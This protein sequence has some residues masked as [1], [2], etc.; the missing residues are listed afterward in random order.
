MQRSGRAATPIRP[1]LARAPLTVAPGHTAAIATRFFAGAKEIDVLDAY[2]AKL[3]IPLFGKAIDWGWFEI[4][5]KP[6]I[7]YLSFLYHLIG[8]FG[9]AVMAL[10][11]TVRGLM[12]PVAQ[13]GFKSMAAMRI[14][15]PKLKDIQERWKDDKVRQQQETM[16]LY[17]TEKVNPVAGCLPVL[18]Q[19][20]IFFALYKVLML[21]IEMRHQAFIVPWIS[22]LSA[23]DPWSPV[24]LFGV[25]PF[26]PHIIA[27]GV[28][29]MILGVTMYMQFKLNPAPADPVQAQMMSIM[30][31]VMMFVMAPFAAGL[32]L[33]WSTSNILTILQQKWLYSQYPEMKTAAVKP[34][35]A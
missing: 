22:D 34:T 25:L 7:K 1:D 27:I 29:P 30:P 23:P 31:W 35:V 2:Q 24:N 32:Q 5:E 18:I 9:L 8:N 3:G 17:K 13:R 20:P 4:L 26:V 11:L 15:Q 21:T 16:A 28:L 33:Y 14:M 6:L 12:F 10:T 19:M